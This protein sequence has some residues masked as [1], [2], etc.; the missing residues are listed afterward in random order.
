[1][2]LFHIP[3]FSQMRIALYWGLGFLTFVVPFGLATGLFDWR[4]VLD[5]A[6]VARSA[7]IAL[8]LP[9]FF[10]E[11][12]FRGPLLALQAR[13]RSVPARAIVLSLALFVLWHPFNGMFIMHDARELFTDWRFLTV[14]TIL[15]AVATVIALQTRSLWLAVLFHWGV[16]LGWKVFLGAPDL[17]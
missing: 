12:F 16:V 7:V 14:A 11:L 8:V 3:S 9:A 13:G 15:G 4:P 10:E 2:S 6:T 1:M 17:F 5:P